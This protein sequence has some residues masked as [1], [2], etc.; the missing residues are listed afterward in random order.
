MNAL[1]VKL[2]GCK[3]A[4][5]NIFVYEVL[6]AL[7]KMHFL[8]QHFNSQTT[9]D[10]AQLL[11]TFCNLTGRNIVRNDIIHDVMSIV[12]LIFNYVIN[13]R[14]NEMALEYSRFK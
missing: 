2:K 11:S 10:C 8:G 1:L 13:Q 4:D 6:S 7:Y 14:N 5:K 12:N 9:K 3:S